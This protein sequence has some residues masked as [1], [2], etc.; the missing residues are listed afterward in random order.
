LGS[1]RGVAIASNILINSQ[2]AR[3]Y[4]VGVSLTN[5]YPMSEPLRLYKYFSPDKLVFFENCL[6]LLT[7]TIYLNDPW[8]FLP[9]GRVASEAEIQKVW[10]ESERQIAQTSIIF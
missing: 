1:F 5:K 10:L 8:D 2:N 9:G 4:N 3:R 6:V 7:P